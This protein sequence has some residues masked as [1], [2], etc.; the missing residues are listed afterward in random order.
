MEKIKSQLE[1]VHGLI[2]EP[3][4]DEKDQE[5]KIMCHFNTN[6]VYKYIMDPDHLIKRR[7]L[8]HGR[9]WET[10][11]TSG[12]T[13]FFDFD[14]YRQ[15][16]SRTIKEYPKQTTRREKGRERERGSEIFGDSSSK[17]STWHLVLFAR[18]LQEIWLVMVW[19]TWPMRGRRPNSM[20]MQ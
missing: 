3:Y 9:N 2:C 19:I 17:V 14:P 15:E 13:N 20:Q 10:Q 11:A 4:I 12:T 5:G 16:C 7:A 6:M 8:E 1:Q 18:I